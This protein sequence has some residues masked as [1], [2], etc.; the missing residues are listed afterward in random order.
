LPRR[1]TAIIGASATGEPSLSAFI[2]RPHRQDRGRRR[3]PPCSGLPD[4]HPRRAHGSRHGNATGPR[5]AGKGPGVHQPPLQPAQRRGHGEPDGDTPCAGLAIAHRAGPP[6]PDRTNAP[7]LR[8]NGRIEA[9]LQ[10][11]HAGP[12]KNPETTPRRTVRLRA[13]KL[14]QPAPGRTSP[15]QAMKDWHNVMAQLFGKG[16][17]YFPGCDTSEQRLR[18]RD[19][20]GRLKQ[21]QGT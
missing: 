3:C 13:G 15:L 14:P 6:A 2:D 8:V 10:G 7:A 1:R 4:P 16:P 17:Y 9:V 20:G 12:G 18:E 11:H 19:K 5:D 21:R